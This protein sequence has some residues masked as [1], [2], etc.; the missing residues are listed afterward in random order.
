MPRVLIV[1]DQLAFRR[2]MGRL[3]ERDGFQVD[4]A[5]NVPAA[6]KSCVERRPH[7]VLLDWILN[8]GLGGDGFM[9]ASRQL[10]PAPPI[11]AVTEVPVTDLDEAAVL[12]RGARLF[13]R[14][15]E[16]SRDPEAFVRHVRALADLSAS[17][18]PPP[19]EFITRGDLRFAPS[20]GTLLIRGKR[21][22]LNPK[23]HAL[24]GVLLRRPGVLHRPEHLWEAVWGREPDEGWHHVVDNRVS[25][26]RR[27]LGADWG[28]RLLSRKGQ[29]YLFI[30]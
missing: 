2:V 27:K 7:V 14:K 12:Q 1:D 5:E 11:I 19:E 3:L 29:G 16:I 24:L 28:A 17:E 20:S 8:D 23:E 6:L 30:A 10:K 13:M 15:I 26:L 4:H 21:V 22:E 18:T 9:K 25:S